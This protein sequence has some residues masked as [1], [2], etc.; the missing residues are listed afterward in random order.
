METEK[1]PPQAGPAARWWALG[2]I[3]LALLAVGLDVTILNVA[4]PT[5]STSLHASIGDLQWFATGYTLVMAAM[6]LPAGML[7]D[8][9]GRKKLLLASLVLFGAASLWCAYAG[10]AGMLVAARVTLGMAAAFLTPLSTSVFLVLFPQGAERQKA[11]AVLS[12]AMMLG[13]PLGPIL[14]GLLLQ[15]YWWGSVFL[16]NVPLVVLAV[17]AVTVLVPESRSPLTP[18]VDGV[19][20]L[21]S[22]AGLVGVTYGVIQAGERS[23]TD[24]RALVPLLAGAVVL[25]ILVLWERRVAR[26]RQ[27]LIDLT[28]F[29]S[30]G[31]TWGTIFSI[32]VSF[33]MFGLMFFLPLYSQAVQGSDALGAGLKLLPMIGGLLV[34]ASVVGRI[35]PEVGVRSIP[36]LGF[37]LMAAGL[38]L[39]ATTEVGTGF[40]FTA[41]W[42]VVMGVGL[43]MAM[44][45]TMTAALNALSTERAGVGSALIQALRQVGGAIGIALLGA[46]AN[47]GYRNQLRL[48]ELPA[49]IEDAIR[50]GVSTGVQVAERLGQPQL[51]A[52]VRSAFV[53]AMDTT[54]L[55]CGGIA[56]TAAILAAVSCAPRRRRRPTGRRAPRRPSRARSRCRVRSEPGWPGVRSEPGW[57]GSRRPAGIRLSPAGPA[58]GR[59]TAGP[60]EPG[61]RRPAGSWAGSARPGAQPAQHPG[62]GEADRAGRRLHGRAVADQVLGPLHPQQLLVAQRR[63]PGRL[64]RTAGSASV[65]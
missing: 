8:R 43:G 9:L 24:P 38:F 1:T 62:V 42:L 37:A 45:R 29:R 59:D 3:G 13:L 25:A 11:M 23:W 60:A 27:P 32:M 40:G 20:V 39:G 64:G 56:A 63:Q 7:G 44:T 15:H 61:S 10:S 31:F 41:T 52:A 49:E 6:L 35:R 50:G 34:G 47:S 58:S 22:S 33:A 36:V 21:L 5:M 18:R 26:T 30:P 55:V 4:L 54:L 2:A 17:F 51:V 14:G 19:G 48:P 16:I 28:L 57:P 53:D 46:F 12:S 65:R